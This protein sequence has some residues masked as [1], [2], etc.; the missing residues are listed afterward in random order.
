MRKQ[1]KR[2]LA[3]EGATC[4]SPCLHSVKALVKRYSLPLGPMPPSGRPS[5]TRAF[6]YVKH[7]G[8]ELLTSAVEQGVVG[9][10]RTT[11]R[12]VENYKD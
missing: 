1:L 8:K 5:A 7:G 12:I 10:G 3:R 2:K 11:Q 6:G 4:R 9:D